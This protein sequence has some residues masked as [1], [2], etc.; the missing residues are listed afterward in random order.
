MDLRIATQT[1]QA[2]AVRKMREAILMGVFQPGD[3]LVEGDMCERLGIS[4]PSLREALRSLEAEKLIAI[5]PNKGPMIPILTVDEA[6]NIYGVRALLEGEAAALYTPRASDEDLAA[7]GRALSAF[8]TA[9]K[10]ADTQALIEC[11]QRFYEPLLAGCGNQIILDIL[12]SLMAR[13]TFLRSKSMSLKG[14]SQKSAREMR[15]IY[16]AI[17]A[18][19]PEA[20]RLAATT[21]VRRACE[22][23]IT[24]YGVPGLAGKRT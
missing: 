11:T 24:A 10:N 5:V 19:D 4:R 23:A 20:A 16:K 2:Q 8:E 22:A 15:A 9:V 6:K 3:R 12:N 14:R 18:R 13:I 21:H 7:M 1:V 17:L